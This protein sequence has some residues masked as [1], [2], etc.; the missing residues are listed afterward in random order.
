M[1]AHLEQ[2]SANFRGKIVLV[3]GAFGFIGRHVVERLFAAGAV[4]RLLHRGGAESASEIARV[5]TPCRG[6]LLEPDLWE[7]LLPGV[8]TV[9]HL[10]AQTSARASERDPMADYRANV[11][12]MVRLLEACRRLGVSPRIVFA[13][14]ETQAGIPRALPL[15]GAESDHPVTPYDLHKLMAE[16]CLEFSVRRGEVRGTTLRLPTVYGAGTRERS[17]DNGVVNAMIR[18]ALTGKGLSIYGDGKRLRDFVHVKDVARAF[19]LA[20]CSDGCNGRHFLVGSGEPRTVADAVHAI[21]SAVENVTGRAVPVSHVS[22]PRDEL[23]LAR[24]DFSVDPSAFFGETG[25]KAGFGLEA[26]IADTVMAL[27]AA[28]QGN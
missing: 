4:L 8:D 26:G 20:A 7:R 18:A 24:A 11:E 1:D 22:P 17:P 21:A 9:F 13:G 27:N 10:A 28:L 12:P 25:W 19:A 14:S 5:G 6:D 16:Q 3:T 23:A 15:T 2:E